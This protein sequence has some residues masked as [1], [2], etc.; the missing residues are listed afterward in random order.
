MG[1]ASVSQTSKRTQI[2]FQVT[3]QQS[4]MQSLRT[5]FMNTIV[6]PQYSLTHR[7]ENYGLQFLKGASQVVPVVNNPPA[8]ARDIRDPS[9]I[10]GSGR[11]P[12]RRKWQPTSVFL[13]REAHGQRSLVG[14]S[15]WGCKES[16]TTET[17]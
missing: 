13:H 17:T 11:F 9:S 10:P 1:M 4:E 15:P 16:D 12:W 14:Y 7:L 6:N 2:S 5:I 8:N 3:I